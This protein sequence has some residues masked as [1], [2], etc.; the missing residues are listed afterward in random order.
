MLS[1][2]AFQTVPCLIR[3]WLATLLQRRLPGLETINRSYQTF[4]LLGCLCFN[5]NSIGKIEACC[6]YHCPD[7]VPGSQRSYEPV[8]QKVSIQSPACASGLMPEMK[9]LGG[10]REGEG[11]VKFRDVQ[12]GRHVKE[13]ERTENRFRPCVVRHCT[14]TN[15]LKK[16]IGVHLI[17][18]R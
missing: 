7:T 8:E 15:M 9:E 16:E 18:F 4:E 14:Q 10:R 3:P 11:V 17:L 5:I 2:F 1:V 13:T 6:K 12:I